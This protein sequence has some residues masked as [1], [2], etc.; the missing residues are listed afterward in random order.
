MFSTNKNKGICLVRK[1][2]FFILLFLVAGLLSVSGCSSYDKPINKI[3]PVVSSPSA[4]VLKQGQKVKVMCWNVQYMAGKNYIFFYDVSDGS[5][6]DTRPSSVDI[7]ITLKEVAS[8]V[9]K[10]N[11]DIILFQE[12]D[13]GSRRTDGDDQLALLLPMISAEYRCHATAFYHKCC[14]V[15]HPKILGSVGMKLATV[16][17]YQISEAIRHQLALKKQNAIVQS[18]D[19]HRAMLETRIPVEGGNDFIVMNTHLE[20]FAQNDDTMVKQVYQIKEFMDKYTAA[21]N[22]WI[23]GGDTNLLP[24]G[25]A[26]EELPAKH[27]FW[28]NSKSEIG[29]ITDKY[30]SVPSITNANS[31]DRGLWFTH[32]PNDVDATRPDRILDYIFYSDL[33]KLDLNKVVQEDAWKISDHEPI[34]AEFFLP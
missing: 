2:S 9:S 14:F 20:A 21:G 17:K 25:V 3:M 30:K 24:P 32:F 23:L 26:Y 28:Y 10:E 13:D 7:A 4:P 8:M 5:G 34:I 22:P 11:P 15:P 12:I 33:L 19:L 29:I 18:F 31:K 6:K 16:S 27:K 1:Y